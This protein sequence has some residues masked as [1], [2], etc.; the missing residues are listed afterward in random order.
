[1]ASNLRFYMEEEK[2]FW[3]LWRKTD[4]DLWRKTTFQTVVWCSHSMKYFSEILFSTMLRAMCLISS[5]TVNIL[6]SILQLQSTAHANKN[7]EA[8]YTLSIYFTSELND[9]K[10][11]GLWEQ[12][13]DLPFQGFI[14]HT[15]SFKTVYFVLIFLFLFRSRSDKLMRHMKE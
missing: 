14:S 13:R 3:D 8:L 15:C 10:P 12:F 11:L 4:G 1:M 6:F 5:S 7:Y 9:E 2:D